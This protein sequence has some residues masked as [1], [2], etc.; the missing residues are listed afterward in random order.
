VGRDPVAQILERLDRPV[1]PPAKFAESL[2]SRLIGEL[3]AERVAGVPSPLRRP[4]LPRLSLAAAGL[5]LAAVV[6]IVVSVFLLASSP[7]SALAVH[8]V[9]PLECGGRGDGP[10]H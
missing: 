10:R 5:A 7:P 2:L 8:G 4:W 9:R 1:E 3:E 6:S